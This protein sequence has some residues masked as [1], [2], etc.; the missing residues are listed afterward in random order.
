MRLEARNMAL[1]RGSL[2]IPYA[3]FVNDEQGRLVS[4]NKVAE[5]LLGYHGADVIGRSCHEVVCGRDIFGNRFCLPG[6]SRVATAHH[7]RPLHDFIMDMRTARGK[8]LRAELSVR[9][10]RITTSGR[11]L[12][13]NRV[14]AIDN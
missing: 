8:L 11:I 1:R 7:G 6:C 12:T 13:I 14:R 3:R 5:R 4:W 9:S 10:R 2:R